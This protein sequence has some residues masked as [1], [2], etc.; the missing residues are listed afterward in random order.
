VVLLAD[1]ALAEAQQRIQAP[2]A[3]NP[4]TEP[5]FAQALGALAAR[6][7]LVSGNGPWSPDER[8]SLIET[9]TQPA[10]S[11]TAREAHHLLESER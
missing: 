5:S 3:R 11:A 6:R 4:T 1:R 8:A 10:R 2:P 9:L 7:S